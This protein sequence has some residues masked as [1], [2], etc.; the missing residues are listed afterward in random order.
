MTKKT[1]NN[2]EP[3]YNYEMNEANKN[4]VEP[5]N[6]KSFSGF[7]LQFCENCIQMTNHLY[8][9]CQKCKGNVL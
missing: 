2:I 4:F 1:Y 6:I 8:N 7:E 3:Q 9:K 5:D